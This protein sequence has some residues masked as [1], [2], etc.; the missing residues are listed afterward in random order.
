M[1]RA[2]P[3]AQHRSRLTRIPE[4]DSLPCHLFS[5]I[6]SYGYAMNFIIGSE[7]YDHLEKVVDRIE[8]VSNEIN[9]IVI[10]Q[11]FTWVARRDNYIVG[12]PNPLNRLDRPVVPICALDNRPMMRSTTATLE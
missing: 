12:P 1:R 5:R 2:E 7:L 10:D 3:A 11:P 4:P 9:S 6:L 8:D